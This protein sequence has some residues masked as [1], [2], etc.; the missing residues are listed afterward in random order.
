[1]SQLPVQP[2]RPPGRFRLRWPTFYLDLN[3]PRHRRNLGLGCLGLIALLSLLAFGGYTAYTWTDSAGFCGVTCHPMEPEFTRFEVSEHK[4]VECVKCHIGPGVSFFVRSK[5]DGIRQ[6]FATVFD[7]HSVPIESPVHNLRPARETCET[8]HTPTS[9]KD[10]IIKR[11]LHFDND[12]ANTPIQS[13]LILKMGG[14]QQSTGTA[15]GIHWHSNA[16][17]YYIAEDRQRQIISWVGVEQP[18]GSLVE[19][20]AQDKLTLA[21]TNFVEE[22]RASGEMRLMDCIDCHN[23]AAH[24]IPTPAEAVD[25]ALR[26]G[27]LSRG[28]PFIRA[29]AI[30]VLTPAY[31]SDTA[32]HAAIDGLAEFYRVWQAD[33]YATHQAE[34]T[35]TIEELKRIYN[36]T[37]FPEMRTNWETHPNNV[38]HGTFLGCFRCHDDKHLTNDGSAQPQTISAQ[39]NTC[40]TVPIIGRGAVTRIEEN[41]QVLADPNSLPIV[42]APVLIGAA[43]ASHEDWSWTLEHRGITDAE[44]RLCNDC[45]GQ[46]FCA[47]E[48]CHNLS[49]PENMLFA[50]AQEFK[51]QGGQVCYICHQNNIMCNKCHPAGIMQNP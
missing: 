44:T 4:N 20:F 31:A 16:K 29:K 7:T 23:R 15:N 24:V 5:I 33:Y 22:A 18:D 14:W 30:E 40:H 27:T 3:Q 38:K 37:N 36:E 43:P 26:A 17:V 25:T 13:S 46:A 32:A 2:T 48:V 49:H 12:I 9:F 50:H 19:Y 11:N 28:V 1:M 34:L 6:V 21:N 41:G 45:H 51:Q 8:C 42:E 47:N 35:Q 10:N 39:C